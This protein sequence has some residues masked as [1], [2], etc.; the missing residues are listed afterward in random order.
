MVDLTQNV[1]V[2][3]GSTATGKSELAQILA[4]KLNGEVISADSMQVYRGMDIGT[5]KIPPDKR[6]VKHF[7]LD[8][9]NP[10]EPYSA[11]LF[12]PYARDCFYDIDSRSKRCVLVGGTG[13]YIRAAIDDYRF[14]ETDQVDNPVRDYYTSYAQ[15]KGDLALWNILNERDPESAALIH[16]HNI[17]R[18]VRALELLENETSYAQQ[19]KDLTSLAQYIPADFIGLMLDTD[20]LNKRIDLRV[21]AMI[22]EGLVD[23]VERLLGKGLRNGLTSAQAIGYKEIVAFFDGECTLD[24]AIANIK[25]ATHHYA[26]RQRTWFRKDK[27]IHWIDA[28]KSMEEITDITLDILQNNET[29]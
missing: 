17:R 26:K 10:G 29:L 15:K 21:D 18:V 11:A 27:R 20:L 14:V 4:V 12:Q 19:V 2:I 13:L 7:G 3:V 5:G 6:L 8:L 1:I 28:N 24:K 23:E 25:L 16:P 22:E 9:V